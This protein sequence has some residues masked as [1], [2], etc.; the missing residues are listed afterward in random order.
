MTSRFWIIKQY[1]TKVA[2]QLF[3]YALGC[4]S[5]LIVFWKGEQAT[6]LMLA[7]GWA[8]ENLYG[9]IFGVVAVAAGFLLAFYAIVASANSGLLKSIKHSE[10]YER[11]R[12]TVKISLIYSLIFLIFDVAYIVAEPLPVAGEGLAEV[13]V[14]V[15][16]TVMV[17]AFFGRVVGSFFILLD[18][19]RQPRRG[20]G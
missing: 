1:S 20:A 15:G 9:A 13:S 7:R 19:D 8:P 17:F 16:Y 11:Y 2:Y 3:P 12:S 18:D 14:W 5:G 6:V 4:I 10:P